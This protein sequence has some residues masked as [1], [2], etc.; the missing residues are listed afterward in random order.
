MAEPPPPPKWPPK[1]LG[2][3]KPLPAEEVVNHDISKIK[4]TIAT[5]VSVRAVLRKSCCREEAYFTANAG[6]LPLNDNVN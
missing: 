4:K 1:G 3:R 6:R 2:V 5:F